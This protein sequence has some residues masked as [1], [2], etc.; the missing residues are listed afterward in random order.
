MAKNNSTLQRSFNRFLKNRSA[1][2]GLIIIA[3]AIIIAI[4]GYSITPDST[5]DANDQ[6]LQITNKQP[7]FKVTILQ[8]RKNK[9]VEEKSFFHNMLYG[10]ENIYELIPIN[11]YLVKNDSILI[12]EY[13][14]SDSRKSY[15]SF[16]LADIIEPLNSD[17]FNYSIQKESISFTT[18]DGIKNN[19]TLSELQSKAKAQ[20]VIKT[21]YLGT[22]KFGRDMFSRLIIGVRISL[23]V[24]LIAVIISIVIGVLLG[25][26]AGYFRGWLDEI[27]MWFINV[28]WSVPTLLLVFAMTLAIGKGFWQ[29]FIAVGLT[30]WVEAARIVR[31]QV[32]SLR[33]MQYVEAAHSLGYSHVRIIFLHILPNTVGPLAVIAATNFASAIII[34]AGLSFL[35]IG[36][37]PPTPSWGG[38]LNENY[39]YIIGENP[40]LAIIPGIAIMIMVLAFNFVGNGLRDAMDVKTSI[41]K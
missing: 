17:N 32:L 12:N 5:A 34:E 18:I 6:I 27:I 25:A 37:Q 14:G 8:K 19:I 4:L 33:E 28:I 38:M 41:D 35:G 7:G 3:F 16:L 11:S 20:I 24:G 31:G 9:L 10:K 40:F 23:S 1:I 29:I 36:V 2:V 22:D 21:F 15:K 39:G 26:L 30:M 13:T